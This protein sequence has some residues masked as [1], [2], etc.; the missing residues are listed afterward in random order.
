MNIA[1]YLDALEAHRVIA[2]PSGGVARQIA[3]LTS[4]GVRFTEHGN[5]TPD[6]IARWAANVE[7]VTATT[8]TWK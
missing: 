4:Q 8:T 1:E 7:G 3:T 6:E 2:R 5:A